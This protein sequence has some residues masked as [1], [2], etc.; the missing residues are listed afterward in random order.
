MV[1]CVRR[2]SCVSLCC[3][4]VVGEC[5]L[6]LTLSQFWSSLGPSSIQVELSF[7]GLAVSPVAADTSSTA[8]VAAQTLM[9]DAAAGPL[10]VCVRG[11]V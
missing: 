2:V 5:S 9:L 10:K 1:L 4:Q 3:C 6:E 8:A 7:H 11:G